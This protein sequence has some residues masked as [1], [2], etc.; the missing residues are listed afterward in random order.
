MYVRNCSYE[1]M[2]LTVYLIFFLIFLLENF[3]IQMYIGNWLKLDISYQ[4]T[5][6]DTFEFVKYVVNKSIIIKDGISWFGTANNHFWLNKKL[7]WLV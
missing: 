4:Y 6:D 7:L 2:K 5:F 1:Y 3:C